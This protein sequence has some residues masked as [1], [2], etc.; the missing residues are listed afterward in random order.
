[1]TTAL[2]A[3]SLVEKVEAIQVCFILRMRDQWSNWMQ[4]EC[5][6]VYMDSYV[7]SNGPCFIPTWQ[8][9]HVSIIFKNHL[10]EV[11]L[12]QNNPLGDHGTPKSYN[13]QFLIF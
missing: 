13:H 2:Q 9:D 7:A 5:K 12:T 10:L 8:M 4:G 6:L 3:L 11:G 1:M